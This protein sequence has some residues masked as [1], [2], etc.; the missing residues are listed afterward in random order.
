MLESFDG[1][2]PQA[3]FGFVDDTQKAEIVVGV[4]EDPEIADDVLDLRPLIKAHSAD[5]FEAQPLAAESLLEGAGESVDPIEDCDL[6]GGSAFG[7]ECLDLLGDVAGFVA[8]VE[9][10][11][12]LDFGT[13]TPVAEQRF[14]QSAAVVLDEIV[15]RFKDGS[16]GAIV[17]FEFDH[18]GIVEMFVKLQDVSEIGSPPAV[19]ALVVVAHDAEIVVFAAEQAEKFVLQFVG[20]LILVDHDVLVAFTGLPP[21]IVVLFE[22]AVAEHQ[23]IIEIDEIVLFDVALVGLVDPCGFLVIGKLRLGDD[24]LRAEEGVFVFGDFAGQEREV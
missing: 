12:Q 19:D 9:G 20:I 13:F 24:L 1:G 14:S 3:A 17:D 8:L 23:Q 18:L 16:G 21:E 7:E 15:G 2:L 5:Q 6:F 10:V 4:G 11:E 22:D